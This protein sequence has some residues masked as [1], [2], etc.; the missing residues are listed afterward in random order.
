LLVAFATFPLQGSRPPEIVR[1]SL[2]AGGGAG[3]DE[4]AGSAARR[5][6]VEHPVDGRPSKQLP[7]KQPPA[8]MRR[9]KLHPLRSQ[10]H[11]DPVRRAPRDAS[12][13]EVAAIS[14]G[15][16]A[17]NGEIASGSGGASAG[18]FGAGQSGGVGGDALRRKASC[19][20]CPPPDYPLLARRRGWQ[21]SVD[22]GFRLQ[23][24]G[25][26]G[27]AQIHRSSGYAALDR[28]ALSVARRSRFRADSSEAEL[29]IEY[30]FEL[31]SA[32]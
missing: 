16:A 17:K 24:D 12:Q 26:V 4:S 27:Q 8:A 7:A 19:L 29:Y 1:V 11:P 9:T 30:R 15:S 14:P 18:D 20:Y 3:A 5:P 13:P 32:R 6:V 21:G 10:T 2:I 28:A 25:S 22:I 23:A 31:S